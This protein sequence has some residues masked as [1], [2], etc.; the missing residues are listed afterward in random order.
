[1]PKHTRYSDEQY[2]VDA[3]VQLRI[4]G[5]LCVFA[6]DDLAVGRNHAEIGDI[7]FQYGSL[8]DDAKRREAAD[9]KN[10]ISAFESH[11]MRR[12]TIP[13]SATHVCDEGFFF[14]PK[15]SR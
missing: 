5:D 6:K 14:T 9:A 15:M 10:R 12:E 2:A 4:V 8:C 3:A 7:H 13:K 1:M 11:K